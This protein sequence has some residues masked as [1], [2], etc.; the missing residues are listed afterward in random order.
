VVVYGA[1]DLAV[2]LLP[3]GSLRHVGSDRRISATCRQ[4]D[5]QVDIPYDENRT[6]CISTWHRSD[7]GSRGA[8]RTVNKDH[9]AQI[10]AFRDGWA[11]STVAQIQVL[12]DG[13][14]SSTLALIDYQ[15]IL[16]TGSIDVQNK[17]I[18]LRRRLP[19]RLTGQSRGDYSWWMFDL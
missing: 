1:S 3:R 12:G 7:G 19:A 4:S 15:L 14:A 6:D 9:V 11:D 5:G 8:N 2:R 13:W 18:E 10:R 16:G 17:N